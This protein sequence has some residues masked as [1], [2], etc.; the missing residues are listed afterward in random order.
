MWLLSYLVPLRFIVF[1]RYGRPQAAR[2][3][4]KYQRPQDPL[5]LKSWLDFHQS[6]LSGVNPKSPSLRQSRLAKNHVWILTAERK[7]RDFCPKASIS[8]RMILS[9]NSLE[10]AQWEKSA[11]SMKTS[12]SFCPVD[13]CMLRPFFRLSCHPLL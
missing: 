13:V 6:P 11:D 10:I 7:Q 2:G 3:K 8:A 12:R 5:L 4:N 9:W 1:F